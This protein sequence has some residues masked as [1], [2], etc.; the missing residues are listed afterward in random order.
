MARSRNHR[1]DVSQWDCAACLLE[2]YPAIPMRGRHAESVSQAAHITRSSPG[3]LR[4]LSDKPGD[5]WCIP[6]CGPDKR[7]HHAQFD[8]DQKGFALG[9][10]EM[11]AR[12]HAA[13]SDDHDI[14]ALTSSMGGGK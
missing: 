7:N 9:L 10:L 13:M 3:R 14:R 12:R 11:F 1:Q 4:A 6:L 8:A 5:Q 2:Q